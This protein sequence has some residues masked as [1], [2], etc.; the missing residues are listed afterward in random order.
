MSQDETDEDMNMDFWTPFRKEYNNI[1][2]PVCLSLMFKLP[3]RKEVLPFPFQVSSHARDPI[4]QVQVP[5]ALHR[6]LV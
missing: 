4:S 2:L 5:R 3:L 1:H 6:L